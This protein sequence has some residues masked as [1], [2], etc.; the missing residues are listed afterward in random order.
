MSNAI[1]EAM[2]SGLPI[3]TTDI[4]ENR[5]LIENDL[6]GILVSVRNSTEIQKN[7]I[8]LL[9]NEN[10]RK[11]LGKNGRKN[12]EKLYSI[13]II[14]HKTQEFYKSLIQA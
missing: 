8:L 3:I 1:M 2:S 9:N 12:I 6:T 7:I 4:P 13:D 5:E 11:F 10:L 14:T